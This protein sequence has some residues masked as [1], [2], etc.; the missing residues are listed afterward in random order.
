MKVSTSSNCSGW[1]DWAFL[2][3]C[4]FLLVFDEFLVDW[5]MCFLAMVFEALIS[6]LFYCN[7]YLMY[8]DCILNIITIRLSQIYIYDIITYMRF[9]HRSSIIYQNQIV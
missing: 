1:L 7:L 9:K 4:I 6:Y 2:N 5:V 8:I 3:D